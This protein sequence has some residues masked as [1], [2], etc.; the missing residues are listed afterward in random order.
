MKLLCDCAWGGNCGALSG[1][2]ADE[3]PPVPTPEEDDDLVEAFVAPLGWGIIT[4]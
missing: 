4:V 1:C 3:L 2:L